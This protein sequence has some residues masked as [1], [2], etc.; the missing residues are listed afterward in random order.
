VYSTI[1]PV[2][3]SQTNTSGKTILGVALRK[4]VQGGGG[5]NT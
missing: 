2:S 5:G 3:W 4:W 1:D